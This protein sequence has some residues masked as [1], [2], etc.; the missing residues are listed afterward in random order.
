STTCRAPRDWRST[1]ASADVDSR[2]V[3]PRAAW[4]PRPLVLRAVAFGSALEKQL[5]HVTKAAEF[6]ERPIV[7]VQAPS[8]GEL[9]LGGSPPKAPKG[10]SHEASQY[11]PGRALVNPKLTQAPERNICRP[12][13]LFRR[14]IQNISSGDTMPTPALRSAVRHA[15]STSTR[16]WACA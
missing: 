5:Q 10:S 6:L 2:H 1:V 8:D 16:P 12:R 13:P 3:D 15:G 11:R 7:S 14:A 4:R 9:F